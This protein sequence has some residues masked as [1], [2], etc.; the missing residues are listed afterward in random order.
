MTKTKKNFLTRFLDFIEKNGNRLPHPATIFL[1]MSGII[2]VLSA[3][4]AYYDVSVTFMAINRKTL[5]VEETTK[6]AIS[7]LKPDG[8]RYMFSSAVENFTGFAPLGTVLVALLG[9]GVADSSGLI[10]TALKKLVSITPAPLV[11]V[12]VVFAGIMSNVASDAGYVVLIPLGAI[13]FLSF[14]KHPVAGMAAAFAGVSGGFSANLMIGTIDPLLGGISTEA[15]RILDPS[16]FVSSTANIYFMIASTFLITAIGW[17]ITTYIVE[18]KLGKYEGDMNI[19]LDAITDDEKRGLL[20][21]NIFTLIFIVTMVF[22]SAPQDAILRNQET[23]SLLAGSPF[24]A[25]IVLII[26]MFFF[27]A[28]LGY[29]IGSRTIKNDKDVVKYMG[30]AMSTM[31]GYLVLVFFAAQFIAFFNYTNIGTIVAVSGANF[32]EAINFKGI[33]LLLAFIIISGFINLFIG[34]AS[35]KWAIMAPVFI[36]MFMQLGYSPE[37][38]QLAYRIGDSTTNIISPLMSYFAVVIAFF[39]KYDKKSGMGTIISIMLPYSFFF[40]IGWSI[41][42]VIWFTLGLPIGINAPLSYSL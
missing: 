15:A 12:V 42:L 25:G 16:Y 6:T 40:M 39:Q 34:S 17:F 21:S 1:I 35:A 33:P 36:P 3:V 19:S 9:V 29:G 18:P 22:L 27:F 23:G 41:L 24:M 10:S 8:I 28:G 32:L 38:T 14:G 37:V 2:V 5:E 26:G 11:T 30:D 31:G 4:M 13:V 20:F 7:M